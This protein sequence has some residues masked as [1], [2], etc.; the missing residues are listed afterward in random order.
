MIESAD[1]VG[2]ALHQE[3]HLISLVVFQFAAALSHK[4]IGIGFSFSVRIKSF[5]GQFL[6]LGS[7]HG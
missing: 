7:G 3:C 2:I 4:D 5:F 1:F 6:G